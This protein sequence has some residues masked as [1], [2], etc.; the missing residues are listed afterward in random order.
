M[1]LANIPHKRDEESAI[2]C[3]RLKKGYGSPSAF[4]NHSAS[5]LQ[6]NDAATEMTGSVSPLSQ[7]CECR[8]GIRWGVNEHDKGKVEFNTDTT[9]DK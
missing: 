6:K 2:N 7:Y 4:F 5:L 1:E 9:T 3:S 8:P